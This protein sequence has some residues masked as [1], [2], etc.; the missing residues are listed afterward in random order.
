MRFFLL[1]RFET[2][3]FGS[4]VLARLL[5][6]FKYGTYTAELL[7]PDVPLGVDAGALGVPSVDLLAPSGL[8]GETS[9]PVLP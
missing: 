5:G 8:V 3:L 4:L 2:A 9:A 7:F 1:T 6:R